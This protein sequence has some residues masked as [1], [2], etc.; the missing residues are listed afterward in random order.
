MNIALHGTPEAS[1]AAGLG[2][3]KAEEGAAAGLKDLALVDVER[4]LRIGGLLSLLI[5]CGVARWRDFVWKHE[6]EKSVYLIVVT[7]YRT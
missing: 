2:P 6:I 1:H 7:I 5:V 3:V 4:R